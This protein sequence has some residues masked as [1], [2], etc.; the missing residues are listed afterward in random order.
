MRFSASRMSPLAPY[1]FLI[2]S[3]FFVGPVAEQILELRVEA[4]LVLE[5]R[6]RRSA[7]IKDLE[8]GA[9]VNGVH[10]LVGVDVFAE[11]LHGSLR[12]RA[13]R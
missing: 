11:A 5:R 10:Q 4:V 1:F 7:F 2:A 13:V 8:R 6:V 12:R 3:Q 9:V